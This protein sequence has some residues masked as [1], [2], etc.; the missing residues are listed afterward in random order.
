MNSSASLEN[1]EEK[2]KLKTLLLLNVTLL[3][4]INDN[5]VCTE[6]FETRVPKKE[7]HCILLDVIIFLRYQIGHRE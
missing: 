6:T 5:S 3:A 1:F 2:P 4:F 7:I